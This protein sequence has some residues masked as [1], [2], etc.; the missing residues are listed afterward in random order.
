MGNIGRII[1]LRKLHDGVGFLITDTKQWHL[2][3]LKVREAYS[4][5]SVFVIFQFM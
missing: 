1:S 2:F 3:I 5:R 4:G